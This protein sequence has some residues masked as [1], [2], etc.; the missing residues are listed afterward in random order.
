MR[1][2]LFDLDDTLMDHEGALAAAVDDWCVELGLSPGQDQR[3]RAI[4][5]KWFARYEAGET[6][7]QG[8]RAG[9]C[10]EFLDR[11]ELSDAAALALYDGYLA[12]Y[13][14]NWRAFPDALRA[15]RAA[16]SR[17]PV[18]ILTNGTAQMQWAKLRAGGLALEGIVMIATVDIGKPKPQPEAYLAG[19][20]ALGTA[21]GETLMIG[22]SLPNDV[23]GA[24]A[25]GLPAVW[26]QRGG[27]GDIT[28]L[29]ELF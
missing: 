18:G 11:P 9:R 26:L 19:C 14:R 13:E 25:A 22:D 12:A 20:E 4:E 3:F 24:Q 27:G 29:A 2:F 7:H 5:K 23:E 17:G 28:S 16:L 8:Q 10:R 21:P 15:L 6:T 1:G